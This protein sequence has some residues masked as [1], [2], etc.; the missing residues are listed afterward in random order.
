MILDEINRVD[1]SRLFG[2]CFSA[3]ENRGEAIDLL[4]SND[5]GKIQLKIPDNL[6][7]IGTMNTSDKSIAHLDIA[8]R[9]RFGFVEI[10]KK[11]LS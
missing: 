7:I 10:V 5:D 2:E 3:L 6:Y 9:R 8:L 11:R 4:G 1:L